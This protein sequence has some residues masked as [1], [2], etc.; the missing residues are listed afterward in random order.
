MIVTS[1]QSEIV[2]KVLFF[3][4]YPWHN[5]HFKIKNIND[6]CLYFNT[7]ILNS[8]CD[9]YSFW[10]SYPEKEVTF[11]EFVELYLKTLL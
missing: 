1:K 10:D 7:N 6:K 3:Y 2:Q 9:R 8:Q 11:K 5:R 4:G